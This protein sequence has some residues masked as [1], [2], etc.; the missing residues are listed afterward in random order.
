MDKRGYWIAHFEATDLEAYRSILKVR[1]S[2][3]DP[4]LHE[5]VTSDQGLVI[6][7]TS[8]S[9]ERIMTGYASQR[10]CQPA[11]GMHSREGLREGLINAS[12]RW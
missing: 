12:G 1:D 8:D 7:A 11:P 4:S 3:F 10:E 9:A 2:Q 6:E 5:Y